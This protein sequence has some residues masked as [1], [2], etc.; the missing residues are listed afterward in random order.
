MPS[1]SSGEGAR[2]GT[3]GKTDEKV[4]WGWNRTSC[5]HLLGSHML[6]RGGGEKKHLSI[7]LTKH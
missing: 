1:H 2:L 3:K 5:I 6:T 4:V 7:I